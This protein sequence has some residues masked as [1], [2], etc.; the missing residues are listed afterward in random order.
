MYTF[1]AP[2]THQVKTWY[3]TF[4]LT[5]DMIFDQFT[6]LSNSTWNEDKSANFDFNVNF[7]IELSTIEKF[8]MYP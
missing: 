6:T 4:R 8:A 3:T 2:V 5:T 7:T 1:F